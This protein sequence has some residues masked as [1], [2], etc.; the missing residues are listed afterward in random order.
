MASGMNG[1]SFA[2][3]GYLP[4]DRKERQQKL[5]ELEKESKLKDQT[6]IF[7]DTPYRNEQLLF[8]ILKVCR[9]DSFLCIAKDIT[10]TNEEIITK[11]VGKWNVK[12]ISLKKVP[13]LFLLYGN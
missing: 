11:S 5:R 13:A 10:G 2:F 7:M 8:D 9:K 3:H 6:Q 4:I 12:D 1:Q